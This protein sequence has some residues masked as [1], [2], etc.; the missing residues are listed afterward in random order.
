MKNTIQNEEFRCLDLSDGL[1]DQPTIQ[2]LEHL[3]NETNL[4]INETY[5]TNEVCS[6][7]QIFG[8]LSKNSMKMTIFFQITEYQI[9]QIEQNIEGE[10]QKDSISLPDITMYS[11]DTISEASAVDVRFMKMSKFLGN[12]CAL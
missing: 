11:F 3:V 12:A 6:S 7:R 10:T 2:D 5:R 9:Q 4:P 1:N 8:T